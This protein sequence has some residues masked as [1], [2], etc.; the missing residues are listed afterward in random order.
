[1]K[2]LPFSTAILAISASFSLYAQNGDN[3]VTAVLNADMGQCTISKH[4]YKVKPAVFK[5]AKLSDK[6]LIV[7]IPAKSVVVLEFK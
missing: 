5:G 7:N 6:A 4:T 2:R 1:M 3:S